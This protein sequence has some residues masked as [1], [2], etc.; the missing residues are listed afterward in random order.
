M[1]NELYIT[2]HILTQPIRESIL[3]IHGAFIEGSGKRVSA[4]LTDTYTVPEGV[5]YVNMLAK[6]DLWFRII[7]SGQTVQG[8]QAQVG[9][10]EFLAQ[11]ERTQ[12][13]VSPGDTIRCV[14]DA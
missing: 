14:L 11:G 9:V 6:N 3:Q 13:P 4:G 5:Q 2:G 8:Q 1:A 12:R 10:H 7:K